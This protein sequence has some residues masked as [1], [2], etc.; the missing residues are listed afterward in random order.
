MSLYLSF[1]VSFIYHCRYKGATLTHSLALQ[2]ASR[3]FLFP[4]LLLAL[5]ATSD[6]CANP[7]VSKYRVQLFPRLSYLSLSSCFFSI[8]LFPRHPQSLPHSKANDNCLASWNVSIQCSPSRVT[9]KNVFHVLKPQTTLYKN[10]KRKK[11]SRKY[12]LRNKVSNCLFNFWYLRPSISPRIFQ[13]TSFLI[14]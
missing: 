9:W 12:R 10:K 14:E 4:F 3:I 6:T 2:F 1:R 7:F 5:S 11:G 8:F 13:S